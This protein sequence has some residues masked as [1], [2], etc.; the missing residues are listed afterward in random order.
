MQSYLNIRNH[1]NILNKIPEKSKVLEDIIIEWTEKLKTKNKP[2][3]KFENKYKHKGTK[4][5]KSKVIK[6]KQ[7]HE[8]GVKG[9]DIASD[10]KLSSSL[11]SKVINNNRY[12]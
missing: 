8:Q 1:I 4:L 11:I 5:T 3:K 12:F 9:I 10:L 6:I 7:L 2:I